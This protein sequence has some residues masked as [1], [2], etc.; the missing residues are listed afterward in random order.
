MQI[1][2]IHNKIYSNKILHIIRI[3]L[4]NHFRYL[5]MNVITMENHMNSIIDRSLRC[6]VYREIQ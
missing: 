2:N 6:I 1:G 5:R 3:R 4:I